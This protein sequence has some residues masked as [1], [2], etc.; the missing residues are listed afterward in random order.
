MVSANIHKSFP[1]KISL[2][3]FYYLEFVRLIGKGE[4]KFEICTRLQQEINLFLETLSI[5]PSEISRFDRLLKGNI[6]ALPEDQIQSSGYV[7]HTLE[8]SIWCLLTTGNY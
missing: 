5:S 4:S 7:I 1:A 6:A 2:A 3:C 8:A